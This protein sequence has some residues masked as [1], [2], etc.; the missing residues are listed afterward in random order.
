MLLE[1]AFLSGLRVKELRNLE[2]HHLDLERGGLRLDAEWT[3]NRKPSLQPISRSLVERLYTAAELGEAAS[4]YKRF[5]T[6]KGTNLKAPKPPLLYIPSS[7]SRD[8]AKDLSAAGIPKLAP[9]P[10]RQE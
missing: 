8:L 1:T 3:K 10:R 2:T 5:H 9:G 4:L 7:P 6:R